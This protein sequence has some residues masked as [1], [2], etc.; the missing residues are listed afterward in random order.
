MND[1]P[2][3][4]EVLDLSN[5]NL[6]QLPK[7]ITQY[8]NLKVLFLSQ[9]KFTQIPAEISQL[10][11]LE[12]LG[13]RSC[14]LTQIDITSLPK[15]LRW[16]TLTD[17]QI[18]KIPPE[19]NQLKK[20][21]K[22]LLAG[23]QITKIPPEIVACKKLTLLRVSAN[24]LKESPFNLIKQLPN[25]AWY[26]DAGNPFS[27]KKIN[28][29]VPKL[30]WEKVNFKSVIGTS[31]QNKIYQ[32]SIAGQ[33]ADVA[34][35]VFGNQVTSDGYPQDDL[36]ISLIAGQHPNI[37][38][39]LFEITN[40]PDNKFAI[41]LKKVSEEYSNLGLPPDFNTC[42][43]DTFAQDKKLSN[44][45]VMKILQQVGS[46]YAHLHE[47]GIMNGDLYA[48]N[49]LI[50]KN[51]DTYIGDFGAA[52]LYQKKLEPARELIDVK[53]F[54]FL[55]ADL[56]NNVLENDQLTQQLTTL[57]ELCLSAEI[58]KR[59]NFKKINIFLKNIN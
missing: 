26:A 13:M 49:I 37:I 47:L 27:L 59:P 6:A 20:L 54:G 46:A 4:L 24:H 8:K 2:Q 52:S 33:K 35:K 41:A 15:N 58:E 48:H 12:F 32:A 31:A 57:K 45:L 23:N 40:V 1:Q 55:M 10:Q 53:A 43:R 11:K 3:K 18:K 44:K 39:T 19:I 34:I 36:N 22:L 56:L 51:G 5:K 28:E 42:Y 7:E 30:A 14:Q 17:N 38:E 21:A 29:N 50:N 16:L 9:N 25:L